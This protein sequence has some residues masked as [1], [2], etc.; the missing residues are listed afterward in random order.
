MQREDCSG[1]VKTDT[2]LSHMG[3]P[4]EVMGTDIPER[5]V[6]PRA[7]GEHLDV[8]DHIIPRFLPRGLVTQRRALPLEAPTEPFH[9]GIIQAITVSAHTPAHS[10]GCSERLVGATGVLT[11]T[12][13]VM[14]QSG[15]GTSSPKSPTP[16]VLHQR[17]I[18][19]AAHRPPHDL[20]RMQ[21][22]HCRQ[23]YPAFRR[24]QRRDVPRPDGVGRLHI[25][26]PRP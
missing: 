19:S 15:C 24:P 10:M 17:R 21:V 22:Q 11:A 20:A 14:H 6:Q 8:I 4:L 13:R 5:R 18:D 2:Q 26:L 3:Y 25:Q 7:I 9:D 1:Q 16:G 23:L 12:I